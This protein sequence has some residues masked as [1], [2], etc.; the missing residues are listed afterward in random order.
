MFLLRHATA[1]VPI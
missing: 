1:K